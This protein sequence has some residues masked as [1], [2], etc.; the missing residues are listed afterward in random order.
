MVTAVAAG[1]GPAA[2]FWCAQTADCGRILNVTPQ[3]DLC[4]AGQLPGE[5]RAATSHLPAHPPRTPPTRQEAV[6]DVSVGQHCRLHQRRVGDLHTVVQLVAAAGWAI[7][8]KTGERRRS[9]KQETLGQTASRGA[10]QE[11]TGRRV[12]LHHHCLPSNLGRSHSPLAQTTQDRDCVGHRG[13]VH[14][15]LLEAAAGQEEEARG[16]E[17]VRQR[18]GGR[19]EPS[20]SPCPSL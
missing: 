3:L 12:S 9:K 14:V 17:A 11:R 4:S 1:L 8:S 10:A 13:L 19:P 5:E 20:G 16:Q 7:G 6:G 15:D 2:A 18:Q